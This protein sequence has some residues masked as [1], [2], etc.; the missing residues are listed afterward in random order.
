M[1]DWCH[2]RLNLNPKDLQ[3]T[4]W[5]KCEG[6]ADHQHDGPHYYHIVGDDGSYGK[7]V[8]RVEWKEPKP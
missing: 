5:V 1:S 3:G 8:V 7:V 6:V 2:H 4:D